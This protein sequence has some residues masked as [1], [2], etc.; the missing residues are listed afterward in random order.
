M[1]NS[2]RGFDKPQLA[3]GLTFARSRRPL[4]SFSQAMHLDLCVLVE[5]HLVRQKADAGLAQ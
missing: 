3:H 4:I 5:L 1:K 2:E